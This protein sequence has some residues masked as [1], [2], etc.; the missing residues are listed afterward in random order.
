MSRIVSWFSC[1][2]SSAVA[3]WLTLAKYGRDNV[4]IVNIHLID[5]HPDNERFLKD[6]EQWFGKRIEIVTREKYQ[7]SVDNVISESKFL[8]SFYGA[9]CTLELK[10]KVR[11]EYQEPTD[12]QIFG[13]GVNEQKRIK[14]L[15]DSDPFT[16]FEFPLV[17][18]QMTGED[19]R[20]FLYDK[21]IVLPVMYKLGFRNNN[22][23]GC[24][25]AES[26]TYWNHIRKHFPEVFE[27][28]AKQE[29]S[30]NY[31]LC[32]VKGQNV[33]LD[34][35]DPNVGRGYKMPDFSCGAVCDVSLEK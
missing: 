22:C 12:K 14:R 33:F 31:A 3:T 32:R 17:D 10:K 8:R 4:N 18:A 34:E 5:E 28:R 11:F 19:C 24:L 9:K 16:D 6:C 21:G 2:A 7:G 15:L 30:A 35:L 29:R 25:K 23:I 27:K 20:Q 1:G 26:P 13:Y